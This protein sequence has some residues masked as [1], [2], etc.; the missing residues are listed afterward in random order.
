V[1]SVICV[2]ILVIQLVYLTLLLVAFSDKSKAP[3]QVPRPVSIIVCAHDEEENIKELVPLLLQQ[4]HP[5]YE[6][7]VVEDRCNDSTFDYL[8]QATKEHKQ[9]KMVRVA[10]KPEHINGKKFALTLGIKAAKYDWVL[11]TDADCRP[12]SRQWAKRM[13]ENYQNDTKMA[14]GF[15]PYLKSSGLLNDFIRFESFL[16]GIQFMGL[17]RLGRPY[18]GIGRNLAYEKTL[19]LDNKGFNDHLSVTGGDDDLFVNQH[20]TK[21]NTVVKM[22]EESLTFS[23]PKTTW[24]DFYYQK[25]RHLSVGGNYKFFDKLILGLFAFT[26]LFTWFLVVPTAFF[27]P[28][29]FWLVGGFLLRWVLL[30]LLFQNAPIKIGSSFEAWKVP[31]LDFIYAFYYLVA[32]VAAKTAKSIQWKRK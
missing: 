24:T 27:S 10:H 17:A 14:L 18:M 25:L 23:K 7:I 20:A 8:L 32:G 5:Q 16:T 15:S 26:W 6:V 30:S 2:S 1:L 22:G 4:D 31:F 29:I 13:T 11:L 9:L 28:F 12:T 21:K 19:F 3:P